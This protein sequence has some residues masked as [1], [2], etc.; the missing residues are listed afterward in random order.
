MTAIEKCKALTAAMTSVQL[1]TDLGDIEKTS[2]VNVLAALRSEISEAEEVLDTPQHS[3]TW[4]LNKQL[5]ENIEL[6]NNGEKIT[7]VKEYPSG[8][9]Q[10]EKATFVSKLREYGFLSKHGGWIA[11]KGRSTNNYYINPGYVFGVKMYRCSNVTIIP[12]DSKLIDVE[13]GW[14]SD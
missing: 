6:L 13:T 7:L 14:N 12:V 2:L 5:L 10:R 1:R 11:T 3:E 8:L 9:I 4:E